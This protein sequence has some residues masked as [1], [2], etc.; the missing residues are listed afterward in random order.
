MVD[1]KERVQCALCGMTSR[2][3]GW[4]LSQLAHAGFRYVRGQLA[5]PACRRDFPERQVR[6]ALLAY[7]PHGFASLAPTDGLLVCWWSPGRQPRWW[8]DL[9]EAAPS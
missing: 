7:G 9:Q 8:R 5:C 1:W 3:P 6:A 4:R 2:A